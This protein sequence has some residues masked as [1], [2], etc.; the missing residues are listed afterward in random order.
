MSSRR[1]LGARDL[2]KDSGQPRRVQEWPA[3]LRIGSFRLT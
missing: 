2:M 3:C 1:A